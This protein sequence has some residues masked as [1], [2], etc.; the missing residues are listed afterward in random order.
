M[1]LMRVFNV[2]QGLTLGYLVKYMLNLDECKAFVC[3]S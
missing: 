1:F 3:K 2:L